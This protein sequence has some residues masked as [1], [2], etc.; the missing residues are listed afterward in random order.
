MQKEKE[1]SAESNDLSAVDLLKFVKEVSGHAEKEVSRVSMMYKLAATCLTLIVV[2]GI[3]FTFKD[4]SEFR[5]Y[6]REEISE[7]KKLIKE[8]IEHQETRMRERQETLFAQMQLVLSGQVASMGNEVKNRVDEEFKTEKINKLVSSE[9]QK[10]I[11]TIA[12]PII[13]DKISKRIQPTIDE[14]N[15]NVGQIK[16]DIVASRNNIDNLKQVSEFLNV[17]ANAQNDDRKSFDKLDSWGSDPKFYRQNDA[18]QAHKNIIETYQ[19]IPDY[20]DRVSWVNN[21]DPSTLS[22]D[23]L[24]EEF[25]QVE[26]VEQRAGL[27]QYIWNRKDFSKKQ[28]MGLMIETMKNDKSLTVVCKA[29]RLFQNEAMKN[30]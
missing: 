7:Q 4:A 23:L 30:I 8:D 17:V 6:A 3:A 2:F 21:I 1:N 10:R 9:A 29:S 18:Y 5:K 16:D 11:D 27:L 20:N 24:K 12:D 14:V 25:P 19:S 22:F 13:T 26:S 28:K 15:K